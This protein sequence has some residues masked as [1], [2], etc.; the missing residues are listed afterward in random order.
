ME[1]KFIV[2]LTVI[3]LILNG[4]C[5]ARK[6]EKTMST[7]TSIYDFTMTTIDGTAVP[8]SNYHGQ[9]MLIVNTA[10]QCGFTPQYK[11]LQKLYETYKDKGF[12]ILGFPA[13]N[14][15]RQEPGTDS[16]I[17]DFCQLNYGVTFPMFS[18]ISVRGKE[19]HPLYTYLTKK[20]T[21]PDFNGSVKWNFTKF[22]IN[23]NGKIINR[24]KPKIKPED[25]QVTS[26]IEKA[27][28]TP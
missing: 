27:L 22:L 20:E 4:S 11:G 13:N 2:N 15:M 26:A 1:N 7:N 23:K 18:K 17:K 12:M 24:Y 14:F 19:I 9:V 8:L 6:T 21:N 10:S 16:E 25:P 5:S 28:N 3:F